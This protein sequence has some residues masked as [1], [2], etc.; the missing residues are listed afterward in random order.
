MGTRHK[1]KKCK[2]SFNAYDPAALAKMPRV[3]QEAV[4]CFVTKKCAIDKKYLDYIRENAPL[5]VPFAH[6]CRSAKNQAYRDYYQTRK[7]ALALAVSL[8]VVNMT[9]HETGSNGESIAF[10]VRK[11]P[12][13][14][15]FSEFEDA[16]GYDGGTPGAPF[17]ANCYVQDFLRR[18]PYLRLQRQM[19]Y[20]KL[21][22]SD[23]TFYVTKKVFV[24]NARAFHSMF[25]VMNE[26]DEIVTSALMQG[27]GFAELRPLLQKLHHR[28]STFRSKVGRCKLDPRGFK[29]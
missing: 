13:S 8:K 16:K 19:I 29:S 28:Y 15:K 6:M 10:R 5:G 21:L 23:H 20:R 3:V 17:L 25:E 12:N 4:P 24:D 26:Y 1:C 14:L 2:S 27:T 11:E 7:T 9:L 18:E 22:K